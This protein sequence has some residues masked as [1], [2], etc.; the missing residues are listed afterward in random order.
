MINKLC[1]PESLLDEVK[2]AAKTIASRGKVSVRAAK[3]VINLG[4]DADLNTGLA[5]EAIAFAICMA[6]EDAKEGTSAFLEKRKPVFKGG[7]RG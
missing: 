5:I 2:E 1:A 6:G 7:F 4:M 3:E